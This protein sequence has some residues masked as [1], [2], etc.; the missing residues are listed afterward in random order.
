MSTNYRLYRLVIINFILQEFLKL[1]KGN[2]YN[3]SYRYSK[4]NKRNPLTE[5][6]LSPLDLISSTGIL[7][8]YY[9]LINLIIYNSVYI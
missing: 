2:N 3:V 1:Y 6:V 4:S 9:V 7:M 8:V 5:S